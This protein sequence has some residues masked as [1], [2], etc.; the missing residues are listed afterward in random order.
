MQPGSW[1]PNTLYVI[2]VYGMVCAYYS[3]SYERYESTFGSSKS[4]DST[5]AF[6]KTQVYAVL[7]CLQLL[8]R[9]L[10]AMGA[11]SLFLG[12]A[13]LFLRKRYVSIALGFQIF[14]YFSVK[15]IPDTFR[16]WKR[17]KLPYELTFRWGAIWAEQ[18]RPNE[19]IIAGN[20]IV[21][22]ITGAST[23][24]KVRERGCLSHIEFGS[25]REAPE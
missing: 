4:V 19:L 22:R 11:W 14:P 21:Y 9:R 12:N 13:L 23:A 6:L 8:V 5:V 25:F 2:I 15:C 20:K 1:E 17:R 7:S 10:S 16:H 3:L 24:H 18:F